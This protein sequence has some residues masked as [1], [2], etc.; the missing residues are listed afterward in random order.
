MK[1]NYKSVIKR[2]AVA[3]LMTVIT[4]AVHAQEKPIST[5]LSCA[6]FLVEAAY[7]PDSKKL[8]KLHSMVLDPQFK[9]GSC[10]RPFLKIEIIEGWPE[11]YQYAWH[12]ILDKVVPSYEDIEMF[13]DDGH[14]KKFR[15]Y[16]IRT[17]E[18]IGESV[19]INSENTLIPVEI[20]G[21]IS[22]ISMDGGITQ[23][24]TPLEFF[25]GNY[26]HGEELKYKKATKSLIKVFEKTNLRMR[27][28]LMNKM[29]A[30]LIKS[31]VVTKKMG[32]SGLFGDRDELGSRKYLNKQ[33]KRSKLFKKL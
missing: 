4:S 12:I 23:D 6:D 28:K 32:F 29:F 10:A 19:P 8:L 33:L 21:V 7:T 1:L 3:A 16:L 18:L 20:E 25:Y 24:L 30:S 11:G 17:F 9:L 14:E 27:K 2:I 15:A 26:Y 5:E 22:T 31:A 13:I